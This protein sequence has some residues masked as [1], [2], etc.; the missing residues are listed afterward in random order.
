M[1]SSAL[2]ASTLFGDSNFVHIHTYVTFG[3]NFCILVLER[4]TDYSDTSK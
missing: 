4:P 3:I 2:G 1:Q